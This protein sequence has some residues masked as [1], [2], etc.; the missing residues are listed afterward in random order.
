M[1]ATFRPAPAAKP[2]RSRCLTACRSFALV[3]LSTLLIFCGQ[4]RTQTAPE[5]LLIAAASNL[6]GVIEQIGKGFTQQTGVAVKFNFGA[7]AQLAQQLEH[8]AEFD[9]FAAADVAHVD[10]LVQSGAL[11][12]PS[13]AIYARGKVAL[14]VPPG[15]RGEIKQLSDLSGR[16][17]R[18]IAI[19]NPETAPYGATAEQLLRA[20]KLWDA[21]QPKLVRAENVTA[22]KQMASTGNA[23]AAF[24]AYSLVFRE[25][26][27]LVPLDAAKLPPIDQALGIPTR[28]RR[29]DDARR[30]AEYILH[31][32][33]RDSLRAAGY[34]L[35]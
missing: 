1:P 34:D 35:P 19:A 25:P 9:L 11:L 29:P 22:A 7:T 4:P 6:S 32:P 24:T 21:L 26:G 27:T 10:Q 14:W 3:A 5:P 16:A 18:F 15:S 13:R 8:G 20:E 23:D 30:F 2:T 17:V 31:G 28:A 33:G 12:A